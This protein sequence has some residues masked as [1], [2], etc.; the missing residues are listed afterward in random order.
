MQA[1]LFRLAQGNEPDSGPMAAVVP[2]RTAVWYSSGHPATTR[3]GKGLDKPG[4]NEL[5]QR[6][7]GDADMTADTDKPDAQLGDQPPRETLSCA[8]QV[9]DLGHGKQPLDCAIWGFSHHAAF[10]PGKGHLGQLPGV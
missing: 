9:G 7:F 5:A 6:G 3:R 4:S 1:D 8:E 2:G 10:R